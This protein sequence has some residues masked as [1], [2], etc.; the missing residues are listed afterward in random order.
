[1]R[2]KGEREHTGFGHFRSESFKLKGPS[3]STLITS[4]FTL[5]TSEIIILVNTN[6]LIN[7]TKN[8][9]VQG[10]NPGAAAAVESK[11]H[12]GNAG[13]GLAEALRHPVRAVVIEEPARHSLLH[14]RRE[15]VGQT[16]LRPPLPSRIC[17]AHALAVAS[18]CMLRNGEE[19]LE[20]YDSGKQSTESSAR[21][22]SHC[23]LR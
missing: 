19:F 23:V 3:L 17:F 7:I 16:V 11:A 18:T 14:L 13:K 15:F 1:L 8:S 12:L 21:F 6:S 5:K 4:E 2:S 10:S 22:H 9:W 20:N